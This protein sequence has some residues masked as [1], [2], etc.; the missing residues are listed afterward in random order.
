MLVFDQ[1]RKNDPQLQLLT[2]IVCVGL[3]TL[4]AGLWWVQ[5]VNG[6]EYQSTL[7]TQSYRTVRIPSL[8]GKILDR[9]GESLAEN[10]P[11]YSVCLYLEDLSKQFRT[12]YRKMQ[13]V[14][15]VTNNL[16]FWKDWLGFDSVV[17][18]RV[19]LKPEQIASL[20]Q[21]SRFHVVSNIVA[22]IG[23]R[24]GLAV[25]LNPTNLHNHYTKMRAMPLTVLDNLTPEQIARFEESCADILPAELVTQSVRHYP[26]N[27]T[28][29]HLLGYMVSNNDSVEGEEAFF[30]YRLPDFRG[31]VGIEGGMDMTLRGKAGTKTVTVNYLGYRQSEN[32]WAAAENGRNVGLTIDLKLQA[33]CEQSLRTHA[34][35][36]ARGAVVVMN[37][38]TGDILALASSP[39]SNP[40]YFINKF[41]P[42]EWQRWG[43]N[44]IGVQKNRATHE[45][46]QPG[47]TFK[48]IVALAALEKGLDPSETI[49]VEP[50][51]KNPNRGVIYVGRN[52]ESINDTATP[53]PYNLRR[54]LVKSSN[55][56]FVTMGLRPGVFNRVSELAHRL[57]LGERFG[58]DV[59]P[60]M[61]ESAG[62]FP[63]E[64]MI[65]SQWMP[66]DTAHVSIGQGK[67]D[68]TPL[69]MAVL[70]SALANGGNVLWP[71]L[72][73][74]TQTQ[75][76]NALEPSIEF[77]NKRVRDH[78]GVSDRNIRIVREAMLAETE[79]DEDRATGL[80]VRVPGLR[81]CGKTGTAER[82]ERGEI[83]N[84]TWFIS[85]APYEQPRYA[86][87][88]MVEDGQSGG[89]TCAPV[90]H[91]VY[92]ALQKDF[93]GPKTIVQSPRPTVPS[94]IA[95]A[96]GN[97]L[98]RTTNHEPRTN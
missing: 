26:R 51:P 67:M 20:E 83:H 72:V 92:L 7:E 89:G 56:Y 94:R 58:S 18:Q 27:T 3:V 75:D 5:V 46:Y 53:G 98:P 39:S 85:Y 61:Q 30:S 86:V 68:V 62:H 41:P 77:P 88:V 87:V 97:T 52:R 8:R 34:G 57:H 40:N 29:A 55:F 12:T 11:R 65:S 2:L 21:A 32:V 37:V 6:R 47:S 36:E 38:N 80:R 90:A 44:T 28:A 84:T 35:A 93:L 19:R 81:I 74:R 73:A 33:T 96:R 95:D 91:D 79:D 54:A 82:K 78:L 69:Q 15:V 23:S 45:L 16:P 48:P 4:A 63:T 49:H 25:T 50:N 43:D 24:M 60:L 14:K 1:L 9:N 13:P 71:R 22:Q 31:V 76:M 17:T 42:A 59:L 70:T 64:K 66:G 10:R